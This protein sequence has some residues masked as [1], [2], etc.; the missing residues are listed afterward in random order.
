MTTQ[1]ASDAS[2][3]TYPFD[4]VTRSDRYLSPFESDIIVI[5]QSHPLDDKPSPTRFNVGAIELRGRA[6]TGLVESRV[7][8]REY[9]HLLAA[10][11]IAVN[12]AIARTGPSSAGIASRVIT[13]AVYIFTWMLR[14]GF[15]FLSDLTKKA[16]R[17]LG[18]DVARRGWY[19]VLGYDAAMYQLAKRCLKDDGLRRRVMNRV[20]GKQISFSPVQISWEIG[21]PVAGMRIPHWFRQ[22]LITRDLPSMREIQAPEFAKPTV[23]EHRALMQTINRLSTK[24]GFDSIPFVLYRHIK[25][26]ITHEA[27]RRARIANANA[28]AKPSQGEPHRDSVSPHATPN[29]PIK[30]AVQLLKE[31][32]KWIYE[33]KPAVLEMLSILRSGLESQIRNSNDR[34]SAEQ[35]VLDI[36]AALSAH[37]VPLSITEIDGR[38]RQ[39]TKIV[40][41]ALFSSFFLLGLNLGRRPNE[42]VGDSKPYGVYFGCCTRVLPESDDHRIEV[43][44]EKSVKTYGTSWCNHIV[45]DTMSLL[46]SL[47]QCWRP[48]GSPM[49]EPPE[50]KEQARRE[51]LFPSR[52]M[53]LAGFREH[54]REFD[55]RANCGYFFEL[56]G[57]DK[58]L[59]SERQYP[60]RRTFITLYVRRYDCAELLALRDYMLDFRLDSLVPYYRDPAHRLSEEST[61]TL[62]AWSPTGEEN[63]RELLAE[64]RATY[65]KELLVDLLNGKPIGGGFPRL[66]QALLKRFALKPEFT[67]ADIL[68]KGEM[69]AAELLRRGYAAR[70]QENCVCMAGEA[71]HTR[72]HSHCFSGGRL[73]TEDASPKKCHNCVHSMTTKNTLVIMEQESQRAAELSRSSALPSFTR[74]EFAKLSQR[75]R[76]LISLEV[77]LASKTSEL[78]MELVNSW[79]KVLERING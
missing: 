14:N 76:E 12:A 16:V 4:Q 53:T 79:P 42:V 3:S 6:T 37:G 8:I 73:H 15:E 35:T 29:L 32:L 50:D 9:P 17:S 25:N 75:L 63:I 55:I 18:R 40:D 54:P 49:L 11:K 57:V 38:A 13:V 59:F 1:P 26:E 68:I 61:K 60:L 33:Y 24:H 48:L 72:K 23:S 70:E 71:R 30:V 28:R 44:I 31:A 69:I 22:A 10:L 64:E 47:H 74:T 2:S 36:N 39:P 45:V 5:D 65:L 41:T 7:S 52:R 62:Y 43:Y 21:L 19:V 78:F 58:V 46:E 77:A 66:V 20:E 34:Q 27:Q 67:R 56:A 51:K